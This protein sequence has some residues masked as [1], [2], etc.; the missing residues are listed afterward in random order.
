MAELAVN[1]LE[2]RLKQWGMPWPLNKSKALEVVEDTLKRVKR[3]RYSFLPSKLLVE[4]EDVQRIV[5]NA[6]V[7]KTLV[8]PDMIPKLDT[9]RML[10]LLE[11]R[12]ALSILLGLPSRLRLGD[13]NYPEHAVD[14]VGV[15]VV[16]VEPLP[17]TDRLK[18][19]RASTSSLAFTIVTNLDDIS[20]GQIRAA[21]ILPPAVFGDVISEAMY[22]SDPLERQ[23]L[24][25]RVP[26]RMLHGELGGVVMRLVEKI[27]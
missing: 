15:E 6:K 25:R 12:W 23:Y 13:I 5:E 2:R 18:V 19:T 3:V 22:S 20:R 24:G 27:K 7:L 4:S 1:Y 21:A 14:V 16:R 26:R 11:I 9:K 8:I 17:G 10:S